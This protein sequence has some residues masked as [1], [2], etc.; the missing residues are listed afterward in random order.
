MNTNCLGLIII[1]DESTIL[2]NMKIYEILIIFF[3]KCIE[4]KITKEIVNRIIFFVLILEFL[5]KKLNMINNYE[6]TGVVI[7]MQ[8]TTIFGPAIFN[9]L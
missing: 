4:I 8:N 9:R 3:Y 1:I 5:E 7:N 2:F 6:V